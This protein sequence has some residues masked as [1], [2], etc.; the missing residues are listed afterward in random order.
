MQQ[1]LQVVDFYFSQTM[2][3][4]HFV[5]LS[6][7]PQDMTTVVVLTKDPQDMTLNGSQ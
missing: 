3:S 1:K 2:G 5:V 6:K 7:D 4:F